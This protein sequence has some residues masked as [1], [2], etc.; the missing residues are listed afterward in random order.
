MGL[1]PIAFCLQ[2][3]RIR[4]R[5]RTRTHRKASTCK[6]SARGC[7]PKNAAAPPC[8]HVVDTFPPRTPTRHILEALV[9]HAAYWTML[10]LLAAVLIIASDKA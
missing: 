3:Q 2:D 5:H 1:E 7:T 9:E 10:S 6:N 8:G 4:A